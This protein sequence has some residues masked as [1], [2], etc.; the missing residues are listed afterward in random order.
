MPVPVESQAAINPQINYVR[1]EVVAAERRWAP[2]RHAL[3]GDIEVKK[4]GVKYLPMPNPSDQSGENKARYANYKERAVFYNVTRRT[5]DGWNGQVFSRDPIA[6]FDDS[7]DDIWYDVD[8]EGVALDQQA[9]LALGSV[10]SYGR[11]GL[12][13]DYPHVDG[14][15]TIAETAEG[16]LRPTIHFYAPESIINWRTKKIGAKHVLSLVVLVENDT[17]SPDGFS[18]EVK[19]QCRVLRLTEA[20]EYT[21][22]VWEKNANDIWIKTENYM[23]RGPKGEPVSRIL[24]YPIGILKNTMACDLSPTYD[25][26]MLNI[27]HYRNSAD[28]EDSCFMVGQPTPVF[29]GLTQEW[30]EDVFKGNV[31]LGS[32]AA[33]SLPVGG[34]AQLLQVNP[35][36][37]TMEAMKHKEA[38]MVALGARI[39]KD[40]SVSKTL[41]ES[42]MDEAGDNSILATAAKNVS[43]AYRMALAACGYLMGKSPDLAKYSYS[44]NTDFPAARLT[45]NERAQLIQEWQLGA[46][47]QSEMRAGLRRGGVATLDESEYQAEIKKYP[48]PQAQQMAAEQKLAKQELSQQ[49]AGNDHL[50]KGNGGGN[51]AGS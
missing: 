36:T 48:S 40:D 14:P 28:Y 3:G 37:M 9:K 23:M 46:I 27:A 33:V 7:M 17:T 8:G 47:T 20:N 41:G 18:I 26:A 25:L 16:G 39:I 50:N 22:E 2:V 4:Q 51:Q 19:S 10:M 30:V 13:V 29:A 12:L 11:G 5:V 24:F 44:L 21:V 15:K 1:D 35:N 49:G 42:Q 32:R 43:A 6:L 45:P 38:Q 31:E 34:S